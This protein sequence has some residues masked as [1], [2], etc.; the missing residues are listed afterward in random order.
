MF[1]SSKLTLVQPLNYFF[2]SALPFYRMLGRTRYALLDLTR[3]S[4]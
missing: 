3:E 1:G 2:G 4:P